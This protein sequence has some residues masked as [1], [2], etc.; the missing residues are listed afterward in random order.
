M[1]VASVRS[2]NRMPSAVFFFQ[3]YGDSQLL[4]ANIR[5]FSEKL[6]QKRTAK[7]LALFMDAFLK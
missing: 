2:T 7:N 5:E 6:Y 3:G 1:H 4:E